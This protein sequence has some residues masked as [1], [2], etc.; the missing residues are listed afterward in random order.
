M[1]VTV[2]NYALVVSSSY[3][4]LVTNISFARYFNYL[5]IGY[6]LYRSFPNVKSKLLM[7]DSL[8]VH[9]PILSYFMIPTYLTFKNSIFFL[10]TLYVHPNQNVTKCL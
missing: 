4:H 3:L 5:T 10:Y 6:H 2:F 1:F 8:W 9:Y 7:Y